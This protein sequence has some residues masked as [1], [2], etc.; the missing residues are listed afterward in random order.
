MVNS[1]RE[2]TICNS[3]CGGWPPG[4]FSTCFQNVPFLCT[5]KVD[6]F[7]LLFSVLNKW[8]HF[9]DRALCYMRVST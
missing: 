3:L 8:Y 2:K 7:V 1:T 4:P 6:S 9:V 5:Y